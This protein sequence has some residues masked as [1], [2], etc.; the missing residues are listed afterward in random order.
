MISD[1][2]LLPNIHNC[3]INMK[4]HETKLREHLYTYL[5]SQAVNSQEILQIIDGK[6][7]TCPEDLNDPMMVSVDMK[8]CDLFDAVAQV[9]TATQWKKAAFRGLQERLEHKFDTW[10]PNEDTDL[11]RRFVRLIKLEL[12]KIKAGPLHSNAVKHSA[13]NRERLV[14]TVAIRNNMNLIE[15]QHGGL[16]EPENEEI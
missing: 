2:Q 14:L 3:L 1:D 4:Q 8:Y 16:P 13:K 5:T 9:S 11:K 7:C 6:T 10:F 15:E 12:N